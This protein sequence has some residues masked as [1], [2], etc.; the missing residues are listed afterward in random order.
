MADHIALPRTG[1][2]LMSDDQALN[3]LAIYM[4]AQEQWNGGDVCEIAAELLLATGRPP[5]GGQ[6]DEVLAMYR[7]AADEAGY[8][9]DGEE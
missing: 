6:S 2:V 5:V 1:N 7:A 9:H 3:L 8:E 4:G